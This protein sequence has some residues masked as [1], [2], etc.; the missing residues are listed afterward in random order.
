LTANLLGDVNVA[1]LMTP[2]P[3]PGETVIELKQGQYLYDL[4]RK[5]DV[6]LQLLMDV[7]QIKDPRRLRIGQRI[8]IPAI[9]FSLVCDKAENTLTL[10]NNGRFFKEYP[11][12]TGRKADAT[13]SGEFKILNKK[14]DPTWRSPI[15]GKTY[16]PGD[17]NN[18]LGTRWMA[19]E[20]DILGIHGTIHPETV[21]HYASN[22]CIGLLKEDV[23]ELFDLIPVGTP[24]T[25]VGQ[26]DL[27]KHRVI[28]SPEGREVASTE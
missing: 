13:P 14:T 21:G 20:G 18:E 6:P 2:E 10:Y 22:G 26:Q 8:R 7:N 27:T 11:V 5:Y 9:Q 12:R 19:F 24:L 15:D 25:I 3:A 4:A 1:I 16:K 23:E 28:E 17:P